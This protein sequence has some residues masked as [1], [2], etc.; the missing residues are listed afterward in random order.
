MAPINL[1]RFE[2]VVK[3]PTKEDNLKESVDALTDAAKKITEAVEA[4]NTKKEPPLP[5]E[6]L[7]ADTE[8]GSDDKGIPGKD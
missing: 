8:T 7:P 6:D 2:M 1:D 5:E 3:G 4:F